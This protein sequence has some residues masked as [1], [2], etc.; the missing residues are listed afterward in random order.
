MSIGL[1]GSLINDYRREVLHGGSSVDTVTRRAD[2][3]NAI[4]LLKSYRRPDQLRSVFEISIT[5]IPLALIWLAMLLA[6]NVSYW[7]L[8][9]MA[10]PAA[11]FLVRLFMKP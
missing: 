4:Q 3:P 7:L 11:G 9:P 8:L 10:V 5:L 2:A 1:R 6:M